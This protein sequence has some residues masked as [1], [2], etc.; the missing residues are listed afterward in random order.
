MT[1]CKHVQY[2]THHTSL[3][4]ITTFNPYCHHHHARANANANDNNPDTD[5]ADG[6]HDENDL[7]RTPMAV[8]PNKWHHHQTADMVDGPSGLA[9][10]TMTTTTTL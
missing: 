2:V 3:S 5:D 8:A 1:Y 10:S 6:D 4:T 9:T 7:W